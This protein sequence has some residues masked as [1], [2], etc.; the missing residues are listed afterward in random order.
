[1]AYSNGWVGVAA[2]A[3]FYIN[4][5]LASVM[6][7]D[8]FNWKVPSSFRATANSMRSLGFR[9]SYVFIGPATGL[10]ID[11]QGLSTTLA[12]MGA[13][14]TLLF[15]IFMIPLCRQI[16]ELHVGYIPGE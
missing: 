8:A 11:A 4:R 1:M 3:L 9:L 12:I 7:T 6:F 13:I 16:H 5:G 14:A 2:G 15:F 10:L